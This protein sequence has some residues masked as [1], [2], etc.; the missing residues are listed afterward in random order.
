[1]YVDYNS[2]TVS[3]RAFLD[4]VENEIELRIS[5]LNIIRHNVLAKYKRVHRITETEKNYLYYCNILKI[6]L[7]RII[8]I[9]F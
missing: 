7:V 9:Y 1:M 2:K 4:S 5:W 8:V 6:M 3:S